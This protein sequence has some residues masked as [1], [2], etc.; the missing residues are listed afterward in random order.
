MRF[1]LGLILLDY[2]DCTYCKKQYARQD[3]SVA[4]SLGVQC[5]A[6]IE[7]AFQQFLEP[8]VLEG[9]NLYLCEKCNAKRIALKGVRFV[10]LPYILTIGIKR[11][12]FN[13]E[14]MQIEKLFH[15]VVFHEVIDMNLFMVNGTIGSEHGAEEFS[16]SPE[17]IEKREQIKRR[18]LANGPDVYEL[19]SIV[20]HLGRSE[21]GHYY[22]FIKCPKTKR[23]LQFLDSCI[24]QPTPNQI[25]STLGGN[26]QDPGAICLVYRR[27]GE[28]P[29]SSQ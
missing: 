14:N 16:N 9:D 18:F 26:Q 21:S 10:R 25:L 13:F 15:R 12:V 20:A 29:T 23:W 24:Y 19:Y 28:F 2:L 22:A 6:S 5:A 11:F 8:E 17:A 4:F 7:E 27:V 1:W 3:N